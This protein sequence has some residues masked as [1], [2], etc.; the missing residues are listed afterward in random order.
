MILDDDR[1]MYVYLSARNT[2][3]IITSKKVAVVCN[4]QAN[5]EECTQ[6]VLWEKC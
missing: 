5:E 1:S 6:E 2:R 4:M 3:V